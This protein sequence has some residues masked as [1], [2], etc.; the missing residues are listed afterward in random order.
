MEEDIKILQKLVDNCEDCNFSACEE[1]FINW[2]QVQAIKHLLIRY[3]KY[4]ELNNK[5]QK[6]W[7]EKNKEKRKKDFKEYY[8]LHKDNLRKG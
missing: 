3:K 7:Y 8:K 6:N 5:Y 4:R 2:T 1:C